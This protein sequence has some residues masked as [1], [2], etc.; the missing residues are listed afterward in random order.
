MPAHFA[1]DFSI[2]ISPGHIVVPRQ[3]AAVCILCEVPSAACR[4]CLRNR[5][6]AGSQT[7][8]TGAD[9]QPQSNAAHRSL[10]Y[11]G[12]IL[13]LAERSAAGSVHQRLQARRRGSI[14]ALPQTETRVRQVSQLGQAGQS[15]PGADGAD[16]EHVTHDATQTDMVMSRAGASMH[17]LQPFSTC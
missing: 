7:R 3:S 4:N 9:S 6:R 13:P 2:S 15:A 11:I 10:M 16:Q 14:Y 12:L 1:S 8:R 5:D 17:L